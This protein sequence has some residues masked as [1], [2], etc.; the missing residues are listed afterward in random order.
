MKKVNL[1]VVAKRFFLGNIF[2]AALF[3]SMHASASTYTF[4]DGGSDT[5]KANRLEVK[6]VGNV[7]NNIGFDIS[8]Y[9]AKGSNFS[10]VVKDENG[11]VIFEK[12]YSSKQFHKTVELARTEDIKGLNFSIYSD[13]GNLLQSKDVVINTKF[14]EDVLVKIN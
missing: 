13:R 4:K 9:N 5:A 1:S 3:I 10:F 12:T 14:V 11:D 6:Y 2:T 7:S 8:Y